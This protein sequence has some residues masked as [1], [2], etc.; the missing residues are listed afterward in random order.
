MDGRFLVNY[1][2]AFWLFG[3]VYLK[4]GEHLRF[5]SVISLIIDKVLPYFSNYWI[6]HSKPNDLS[7]ELMELNG[8]IENLSK[9][10]LSWLT[11]VLSIQ[12]KTCNITR[13]RIRIAVAVGFSAKKHD[14]LWKKASFFKNKLRCYV[15]INSS[16]LS[17]QWKHLALELAGA[18]CK[19]KIKLIFYVFS[20]VKYVYLFVFFPLLLFPL[21]FSQMHRHNTFSERFFVCMSLFFFSLLLIFGPLMHASNFYWQ[22]THKLGIGLRNLCAAIVQ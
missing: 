22:F 12:S 15:N 1:S 14:F 18:S 3:K 8:T 9:L 20:I 11:R 13:L 6:V 19:S 10:P 4:I 21:S 7:P 16:I 5:S 17:F 2:H